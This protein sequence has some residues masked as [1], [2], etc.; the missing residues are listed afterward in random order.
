MGRIP[1]HEPCRRLARLGWWL[2][3]KRQRYGPGDLA[4]RMAFVVSPEKECWWCD[5]TASRW[6]LLLGWTGGPGGG[7]AGVLGRPQVWRDRGGGGRSGSV[8]VWVFL[9]SRG[10]FRGRVV[11]VVVLGYWSRV[12]GGRVWGVTGAW[13]CLVGGGRVW[14]DKKGH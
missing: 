9:E 13:V 8:P 1:T 2:W 14:K 10:T 3:G 11:L 12:G 7:V 4:L 6:V 5:R